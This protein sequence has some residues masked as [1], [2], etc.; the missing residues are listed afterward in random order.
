MGEKRARY[1]VMS[2]RVNDAEAEAIAR[3]CKLRGCSRQTLLWR[4]VFLGELP[5]KGIDNGT[6]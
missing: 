6:N 1:N 5:G 2:F 4:A 3:V